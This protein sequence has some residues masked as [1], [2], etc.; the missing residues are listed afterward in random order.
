MPWSILDSGS[1][2]F[3]DG[4]SGHAYSYPGGA[5]ASGEL[6]TLSVSS[7]TTVSTPSGWTLGPH[8]V[9]NI[10]AYM[11]YKVAGASEASSVTITTSGNFNT[12]TGYIAY[13]GQAAA[14]P[15]DVSASAFNTSSALTTPTAT[16]A[17]LSGTN[18]LVVAAACLGGMEGGTPTVSSWTGGYTNRLSQQTAGAGTT[19]QHLFV[20]DNY[21]AGTAAAAVSLSFTNGSNN[22][23]TLVAAFKPALATGGPAGIRIVGQ[24]V[25]R[26]STF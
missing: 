22:Q 11:F 25:S 2:G 17:S 3:T 9:H 20:A 4:G 15:F 18:E 19:D 12:A 8:D 23:T 16:T 7:D 14:S 6:L 5:P 26:A 24:A 13:S 1:V 10:G 21:T